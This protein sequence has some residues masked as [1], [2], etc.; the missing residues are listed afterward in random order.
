MNDKKTQ[1]PRLDE[2]LVVIGRSKGENEKVKRAL[3][4][5]IINGHPELDPSPEELRKIA[6]RQEKAAK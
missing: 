4:A 2:V 5:S 1:T 3:I 6:K